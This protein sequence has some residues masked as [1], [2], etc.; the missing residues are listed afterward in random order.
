MA[1]ALYKAGQSNQNAQQSSDDAVKDG[2]V[3][4]AEY[5]ETK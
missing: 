1:E 3:V 2:E 4:D 5:A